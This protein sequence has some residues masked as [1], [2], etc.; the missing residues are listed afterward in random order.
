MTRFDISLLG[1]TA[2]AVAL[3]VWMVAEAV[4]GGREAPQHEQ[5]RELYYSYGPGYF[6]GWEEEWE[7]EEVPAPFRVQIRRM[8]RNMQTMERI[9]WTALIPNVTQAQKAM[10]DFHVALAGNGSPENS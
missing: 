9:M 4:L 5:Q 8:T 2:L 10:M 3:M 7:W 6:S 1:I